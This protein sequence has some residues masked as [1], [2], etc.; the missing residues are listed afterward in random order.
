M[1]LSVARKVLP[2]W[3]RWSVPGEVDRL[4][5]WRLGYSSWMGEPISRSQSMESASPD[6]GA[7]AVREQVV[8]DYQALFEKCPDVLLVLLP[9]APKYT[10]VAATDARLSVTHITRD[11]LGRGLFEV[12]PD[13]ASG[14]SNLRSSLERVR[15]TCRPDTM[16]V[17]KYDIGGPGGKFESRYRSPKNLLSCRR[18]AGCFSSCTAW[19]MSQSSCAPTSS[20]TSCAGRLARWSA[21]SSSEGRELTCLWKGPDTRSRI[22][23]SYCGPRAWRRRGLRQQAEPPL[24]DCVRVSDKRS[25]H[26]HWR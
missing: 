23:G 20:G 8:L 26:P 14:M 5:R 24:R 11:T 10:M 19:R 2:T 12:F 9:D 17:Q 22:S 13:S 15:S 7:T 25:R 18:P 6:P 21:K 3:G 1:L 16:A 4:A